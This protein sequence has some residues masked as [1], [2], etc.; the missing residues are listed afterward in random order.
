M[1]MY[2]DIVCKYPLPLPEDTKGY[3]QDR[4]QTK[5]LENLLNLYEIRDD[6][7]LWL[8]ES[9]HVCTDVDVDGWPIVVEKNKRWTFVKTTRSISMY[10]YQR[11]NGNYDYSIE[12][13]VIFIDGVIDEIKLIKFET[14]DNTIRKENDR[15]FIEELKLRKKFESTL[16]YK[17]IYRPINKLVDYTCIGMYRLGE[18]LSKYSWKIRTKLTI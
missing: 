9:E 4:F 2:D 15:K 3:V 10:D 6:G 14:F 11:S 17:L 13:E 18:F 7:T 16:Q 12:F 5:D 1:G 8:Y